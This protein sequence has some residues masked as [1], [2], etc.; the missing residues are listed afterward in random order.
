[1]KVVPA[2]G[3]QQRAALGAFQNEAGLAC[4][5]AGRRVGGRMVQKQPMKSGTE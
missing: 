5:T 2:V 1:M 4:D 3:V